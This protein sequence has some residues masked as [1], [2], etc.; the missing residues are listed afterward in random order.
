MLNISP[1]TQLYQGASN[2]VAVGKHSPPQTEARVNSGNNQQKSQANPGFFSSLQDRVY[3]TL[4]EAPSYLLSIPIIRNY[5]LRFIMPWVLRD[6]NVEPFKPEI[7]QEKGF[8]VESIQPSKNGVLKT[9][10][11]IYPKTNTGQ[12]VPMVII[13]GA[14]TSAKSLGGCAQAALDANHPVII[15]DLAGLAAKDTFSLKN[16]QNDI[17]GML[18]FASEKYK[19]SA[20]S[21]LAHSFG[22]YNAM[23][24]LTGFLKENPSSMID[25]LLLVSPWDSLYKVASDLWRTDKSGSKQI[26]N[27]LHEVD[28]P[29][30]KALNSVSESQL[31]LIQS[32]ANTE[33]AVTKLY[34]SLGS[35]NLISRIQEVG[36]IFGSKDQH[37]YPSRSRSIANLMK[38]LGFNIRQ[39]QLKDAGHYDATSVNTTSS[40]KNIMQ[41]FSSSGGSLNNYSLAA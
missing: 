24:A 15:G 37:V 30:K 38:D 26:E 4:A 13:H 6:S 19:G 20:I 12:K 7:F 21:I 17:R 40:I 33:V 34:R 11:I 41:T 1:L 23:E 2:L 18:N 35:K 9:K 22:T 39:L 28:S 31:N 5:T 29:Y 36:I 10:Y 32:F 16:I 3:G 8:R 27:L 25:K 14:R